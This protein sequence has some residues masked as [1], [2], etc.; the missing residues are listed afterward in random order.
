MIQQIPMSL[1]AKN[2]GIYDMVPQAILKRSTSFFEKNLKIEFE[3]KSDDL[4]VYEGAAV[5][6]DGQAVAIKHYPGYPA[7]T[8][9]IYLP[10]KIVDVKE[11]TQIIRQ[12]L[13]QLKLK[14]DTIEWERQMDPEL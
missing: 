12:V 5:L 9:T 11:I 4:D 8:V 6:V 14:T 10:S 2:H 7:G 3:K 13:R 1:L